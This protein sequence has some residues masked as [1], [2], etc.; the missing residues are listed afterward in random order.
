M[1]ASARE[2]RDTLPPGTVLAGRY[3]LR[4]VLGRGGSSVVYAA[5]DERGGDVAVKLLDPEPEHRFVERQ[6]LLREARL[7]RTIRHESIVTVRDA[8]ELDDGRAFLVMERLKGRTVADRMSGLFWMPMDETLAVASQLLEALDCAHALGIVHRDVNPANVFLL[9]GDEVRIKLIDF[10]IG[11]DL[12]NPTSRVTQPDIVVGTLG[13]MAPEAL[14]GDDP[15][16]GSD[17]YGAGAT[18]YEML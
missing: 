9:D 12:G 11:R 10:G 3:E 15:S 7:T 4:Y 1:T 5:R 6:R 17:V 16:I 18:I 13:Y 8:G 14:L 2:G